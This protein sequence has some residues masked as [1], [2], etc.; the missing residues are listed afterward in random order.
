LVL[1]F[2][3]DFECYNF[4]SRFQLNLEIGCHVRQVVIK[5]F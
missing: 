1:S 5:M 4:H 2:Q 3:R